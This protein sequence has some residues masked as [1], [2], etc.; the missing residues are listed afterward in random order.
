MNE[1]IRIAKREIGNGEV[2]AV[3]ARELHEFLESKQQFGNWIKSRI[4]EYDFKNGND[5]IS[6]NKVIKRASGGGSR[7]SEYFLTIEMAKELAMVERNDKGKQARQYFIE[8]E[9]IAKQA[10]PMQH[11][12][13]APR[14][15][16]FLEMAQ[17]AE[18]KEKLEAKV[19]EAQPKVEF[20]DAVVEA[21]RKYDF[22]EVAKLLSDEYGVTIGRNKL[23]QLGREIGLLQKGH[24]KNQPYQ[25]FIDGNLMS[26]EIIKISKPPFSKIVIQPLFTSN[27][28]IKLTPK[29]KNYLRKEVAV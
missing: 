29:I 18:E 19:I 26:V 6:F 2:N 23:L 27:G 25:K 9:R 8:C 20:H 5:F 17:M 28:L 4:S 1:L 14:S 16:V 7:T 10:H 24:K 21:D 3:D 15:Q 11:L 12:L 13:T 22:S